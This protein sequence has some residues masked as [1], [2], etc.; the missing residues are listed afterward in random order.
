LKTKNLIY[1]QIIQATYSQQSV[2]HF[3]WIFENFAIETYKMHS[4][5]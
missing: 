2:S 3:R 5:Y 4:K 1:K